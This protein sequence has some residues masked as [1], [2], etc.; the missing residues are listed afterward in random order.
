MIKLFVTGDNH[1]GLK[2]SSHCKGKEIIAK[3]FV[4]FDNMIKKANEEKCNLFIIT[5]DLFDNNKQ[6]LQR[7]I[8]SVMEKL[9][10][11]EGTA[12][13]LPGNHDYYKPEAKLWQQIDNIIKSM[14]NILILNEYRPYEINVDEEKVILYPAFC[15]SLHSEPNENNL[16]WI[17]QQN[18]IHDEAYRIGIAHGAVVGE[19]I[20]REGRYFSMERSE[21]E[22]IPVD[23]WTIG[24]THVPFPRNL[25]EN[26]YTEGERIYNSGTHVQTD[27]SCNTAGECFIIEIEKD[28]GKKTVRA[29][30]YVSGNIGFIR[31][32][33][34]VN[35]D[36]MEEDL[37]KELSQYD[38]NTAID[39]I[40][41]G[42]VSIEEY[43]SKDK[44]I[45]KSLERF[46]ESTYNCDN[47]SRLISEE[48]INKEFAEQSF[49][50]ALLKGLLNNPKEAQLAYEM[51][52]DIRE[53]K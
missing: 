12:V 43:E 27:V 15:T 38:N 16:D 42:A 31:K 25:R 14:D 9:S 23:V 2:Y 26:E 24:H 49:P 22:S 20:D 5:G 30:K 1:I 32:Y 28:N 44:I 48:L 46:F 36:K 41:S 37:K 47:L 51:L 19:T 4:A 34:N 50:A 18:I 45:E 7:D 6:I 33:I 21:L 3:R 52:K 17:K 53:G 13:I 8:K 29:K 11:F 40:L 10:L 39:V 35:A